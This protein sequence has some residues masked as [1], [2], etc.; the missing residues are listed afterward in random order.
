M[1]HPETIICQPKKKIWRD[2]DR[3]EKGTNRKK[4]DRRELQMTELENSG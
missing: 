4:E 2:G 3:T 1:M